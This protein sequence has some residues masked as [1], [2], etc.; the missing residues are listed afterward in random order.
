[1]PLLTSFPE[2]LDLDLSNSSSM[3]NIFKTTIEEADIDLKRCKHC[4][5]WL[6]DCGRCLWQ[7]T[8]H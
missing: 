3:M 2:F 5:V 7:G 6:Y 4:T 1:M 8:T